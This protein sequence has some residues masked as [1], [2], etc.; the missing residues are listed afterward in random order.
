[1]TDKQKK[2]IRG[3][4]EYN[5]EPGPDE[6]KSRAQ[7][8]QR[9]RKIEIAIEKDHNPEE[10]NND[11]VSMQFLSNGMIDKKKY[12]LHFELGEKKTMNY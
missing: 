8:V 7:A 1:M 12:D 5:A 3:Q 6:E 4:A 11:L 2:Q 10:H 9:H